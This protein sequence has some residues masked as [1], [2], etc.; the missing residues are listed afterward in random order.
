[1]VAGVRPR[2]SRRIRIGLLMSLA[3]GVEAL[4]SLGHRG[5]IKIVARAYHGEYFS[6]LGFGNKYG[7]I[8][9]AQRVSF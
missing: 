1:M 3:G 7:C 9:N 6:R 2:S 5:N 4:R 8:T